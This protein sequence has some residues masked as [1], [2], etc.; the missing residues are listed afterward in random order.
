MDVKDYINVENGDINTTPQLESDDKVI[1]PKREKS[2]KVIL[3]NLFRE[4]DKN[5]IVLE[6][7][8]NK[9]AE[10]EDKIEK[11][12]KEIAIDEA[13]HCSEL[14]QGTKYSQADILRLVLDGDFSE[15]GNIRNEIIK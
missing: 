3:N 7:A 14:L 10:T 15:L 8:Q 5:N 13:L 12:R 9:V 2:K 6:K 11:V 4:L 1:K